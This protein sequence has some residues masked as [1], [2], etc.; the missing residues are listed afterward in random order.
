MPDPVIEPQDAIAAEVRRWVDREVIPVVDELEHN[1][2]FPDQLVQGMRD[3][4]LFELMVPQEHGGIGAT[5]VSYS[6]VVEELARGWMSLGGILNTHVIITHL[7]STFG[8][9]DQ[10][11]RYLPQLSTA[12]R[13]GALT[14]TEPNAGSDVQAIQSVA[15]RDGDDYVVNG[16]KL[17]V[18][19]G[20]RGGLFAMAVKTDPRMLIRVIA[21]SHVCW[22]SRTTPALW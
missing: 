19:N 12:E 7:V 1:N 17:F 20:R 3:L 5:Y 11:Q 6:G 18:S 13:R 21:V 16:S 22:C 8:T 9:D 4:G 15:V 2:T 14:I 10:K